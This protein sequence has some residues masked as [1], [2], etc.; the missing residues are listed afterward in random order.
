MS[1]E[2]HEFFYTVH[3]ITVKAAK[4]FHMMEDLLCN[5]IM[6]W[7]PASALLNNTVLKVFIKQN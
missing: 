5:D 6:Y 3:L 2:S 4:C 1:N 7:D